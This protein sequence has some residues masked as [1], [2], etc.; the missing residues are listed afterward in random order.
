MRRLIQAAFVIGLGLV[1]AFA[2]GANPQAEDDVEH[3]L[4]LGQDRLVVFKIHLRVE[5]KSYRQVFIEQTDKY[6]DELDTNKDGVLRGKEWLGIPS[7]NDA[8]QMLGNSSTNR[9]LPTVSRNVVDSSPKD[10]KVT[11]RE[12]RTYLRRVGFTPFSMQINGGNRNNRVTYVAGMRSNSNAA[13]KKLFELLDQN[14]DGRLSTAELKAARQS[15]RKTDFDDDGTISAAELGPV[16]S[17]YSFAIS[18]EIRASQRNNT[19]FLT[20]SSTGTASPQMVRK[21]VQRYDKP[22]GGAKRG[23]GKLSRAELKIDQQHFSKFDRDGDGKLDSTELRFFLRK[24]PANVEMI[25][26]LGK[27][28]SGEK[29]IEILRVDKDLKSVIRRVTDKIANLRLA[30]SQLDIGSNSTRSTT[31]STSTYDRTFETADADNNGYLT[32]DEARRYALFSRSFSLMDADND[33]K[34]F[35]KEMKAYLRRQSSL[36]RSRT[37]LNINDQGRDLFKILDTNRDGRLSR[38]ELA[39]TLERIPAWD[40]DSDQQIAIS[41]IP[42]QYRLSIDRGSPGGMTGVNVLPAAAYS[43]G[44]RVRR[45]YAGPKWFQKMDLNGDRE[46][47]RR[48]FLGRLT[49]FQRLDSNGDGYLSVA[50]AE[51]AESK[52]TTPKPKPVA[53]RKPDHAK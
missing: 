48:E 44:G 32:N 25:V 9:R 42:R 11:R 12:L 27:R 8:R 2:N 14:D 4:Y 16:Q 39:A 17:P 41:E 45:N 49:L 19:E 6:F 51:A 7:V 40:L 28:K 34:V 43:S 36:A 53:A 31:W 52:R 50:E 15:L 38:H 46:V 26:R 33:G 5:G 24:P 23:D 10:G 47:S 13:S 1:P 21:F 29:L 3:L 30:S 20:R 37:I 18:S 35:K 22:E